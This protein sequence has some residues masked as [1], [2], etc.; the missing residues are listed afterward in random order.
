[1]D[2]QKTLCQQVE[3]ALKGGITCLQLREKELPDDE[4]LNDAL[5]IKDLCRRYSVPFFINDNVDVAIKCNADGVHVGQEDMNARDVRSLIGEKMMI[6]VSAHTVEEAL[7][8]ERNGAD[9]L[10]VGTM[11]TTSTK[12]DAEA[13][14]L[15]TLKEICSAV[16]IPVVAIGGLT[17]NNIHELSGTGV[18]GA[19]LVSGIFSAEDIERV[20]RKLLEI[21]RKMVSR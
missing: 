9:Y 19:A 16:G 8:A 17:G 10:G 20:C 1:M 15:D 2:W 7:E 5:A 14:S 6:G 21:S 11:F 4:F 13:V 3:D 18:D 12:P